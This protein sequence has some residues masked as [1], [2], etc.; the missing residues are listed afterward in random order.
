MVEEEKKFLFVGGCFRSG[1][2]LLYACLNQHPKISIL[3]EASLLDSYLPDKLFLH[4]R[5]MDNANAWGKFLSRHGL[6]HH[7]YRAQEM[8]PTPKDIYLHYGAR[9]N[10]EYVGEKNPSYMVVLPQ[11]LEKF[12]GAKIITISRDPAAIYRSVLR[13]GKENAFFGRR[14]M[15]ERVLYFQKKMLADLV[16]LKKRG[17]DVLSITY[18]ELSGDTEKTV[19][20]ICDYLG[21]P[22]EPAMC[23]L[24][25]ADL[26]AVYTAEHHIKLR[27]G[28]IEPTVAR[29]EEK[30]PVSQESLREVW[31]HWQETIAWLR[32]KRET[33]PE[34]KKSPP[35][36]QELENR[37]KVLHFWERWKRRIYHLAPADAIRVFRSAKLLMRTAAAAEAEYIPPE[38]R[39]RNQLRASVLCLFLCAAGGVLTLFYG[40]RISPLAFFFLV[41]LVAGW[42]WGGSRIFWFSL[43]AAFV[44]TLGQFF[45]FY[46]KMG[47]GIVVWNLI[48]RG[49]VFCVFGVFAWHLKSVLLEHMKN[50]WKD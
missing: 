14:G 40:G 18:D 22:Y 32:G 43:F 26:T 10:A 30:I 20:L 47:A 29:E 5:W 31:G 4:S 3:Y 36:I 13:A 25:G 37:G 33:L 45:Y 7:P 44:W 48:S 19:G 27:S 6:P 34:S 42:S 16:E 50:Q 23:S 21:M 2:S 8:F 35:D 28:K 49:L 24:E 9:K 38:K 12:P 46:P 39:R 1:T 17:A 41:P 11:L 15:M